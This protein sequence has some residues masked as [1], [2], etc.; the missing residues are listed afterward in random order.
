MQLRQS[1]TH[2]NFSC[3]NLPNN[4]LAFLT[5]LVLCH[6]CLVIFQSQIFINVCGINAFI[7]PA[8]EEKSCLLK[9][10]K[11]ELLATENGSS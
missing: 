1:Y 9:K 8:T 10:E 2:A 7:N 4:S 5:Y 3:T 11:N 6:S